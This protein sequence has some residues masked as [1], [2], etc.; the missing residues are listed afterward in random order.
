MSIAGDGPLL[1]LVRNALEKVFPH[2]PTKVNSALEQLGGSLRERHDGECVTGLEL[3]IFETRLQALEAEHEPLRAVLELGAEIAA[4]RQRVG[5][6]EL[7][8][9]LRHEPREDDWGTRQSARRA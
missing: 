2:E 1:R 7:S 4:L 9:R 8:R 6:L 3:G 5:D